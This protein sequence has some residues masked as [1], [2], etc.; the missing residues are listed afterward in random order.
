MSE[1]KKEKPDLSKDYLRAAIKDVLNDT[2]SKAEDSKSANGKVVMSQMAV[3]SSN[4]DTIASILGALKK[5]EDYATVQRMSLDVDP[6]KDAYNFSSLYKRRNNLVPPVVLKRLRDTEELI[7]GVILPIRA[8]QLLSFSR[9]R[10]NRFD[11]GFVINVKPNAHTELNEEQIKELK[12]DAIPKLRELL[13]N[14]G[15]N[16]GLTD[17]DKRTLGQFMMETMEDTGIFGW[18][19]SEFRK[20]DKGQFH[21]FRAVDAG[22]IYQV[23]AKKQESQDADNVRKQ[24]E[25]LLRQIYGEKVKPEQFD[26]F[27]DVFT[28]VQVIDDIPQQ[29]FTD[30]EM[31]VMNMN[32]STDIYRNGYPVSPIERIISA[33]TTHIN[34]TTH[35]KMYFVNGRA[36]RNVMVFQSDNLEA[37]DIESIKNQMQAH[38]NSVNSA[39]RM[40]VFGMGSQDKVQVLPLEQ[41][42][43]DMEFQYLADLNKRMIFAAYQMSPDEVAALSYLSKGSQSQTL[44]ESNNEWKLTA[45]RDVGLRPILMMYEDF[46]N[47]RLLPKID[48]KWSTYLRID[49][50]GLDAD[51]PEKEATRLQQDANIY[52]TMDDIMERV[53]KEKIAIGGDFPLNGTFFTILEKYYTKGQILKAFGGDQ[54]KDADKDPNLA[55]CIGDPTSA[56]LFAMKAQAAMQAQMQPQQPDAGQPDGGKQPDQKTEG[57]EAQ[58]PDLDS[59]LSQLG[60]SLGKAEGNLPTSRKELLK[61]HKVA[62]RKIMDSFKDE[63]D[64]MIKAIEAAVSGK[65]PH[66]HED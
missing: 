37:Q 55:Y 66:S 3:S 45:A 18:F 52:L 12:D 2:L 56:Q 13:L 59:A 20:D 48:K 62:K 35:T 49:L 50:E 6:H 17:K 38:I 24:A 39:W 10:A 64:A 44:S 42:A 46:F 53:E 9:P 5:S 63:T 51:S 61:R 15:R 7:G 60:E 54:F 27:Q 8:R 19:A 16:D 65:D 41:G 31:M 34:L 14:C 32:P 4:S 29:V 28:W 1:D 40:P 33:V 25:T 36:A 57:E 58:G 47:E 21:S 11:V 43:R 22:T 23:T 26:K 30:Q